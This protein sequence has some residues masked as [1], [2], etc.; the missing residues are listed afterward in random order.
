[1]AEPATAT[2]APASDNPEKPKDL[3]GPSA[4]QAAAVAENPTT[5]ISP[6]TAQNATDWFLSDAEDDTVAWAWLPV[7][8]APAGRKE[9]IVDF[10]IQVVDRDVIQTKRKE[11]TRTKP[12]GTEE[13]DGM[14][15]NLRIAVEGLLEPN[16]K[17]DSKMRHV[18]GQD[19]IDPGDA[20]RARFAHKPG[21]IDAIAGKILEVS[22]YGSNDVKEVKAA[23]N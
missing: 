22:G 9:K 21:V 20:L 23:G 19:F 8:V 3:T 12:D 6:A 1:M 4:V 16:V 15:A 2:R 13:M 7:N 10:K 5:D 17:G 11:A 18:R 14:E